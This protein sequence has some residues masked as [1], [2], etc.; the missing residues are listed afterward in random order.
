MINKVNSF[1]KRV[2]F[3]LLQVLG[4]TSLFASFGCLPAMYGIPVAMY[5]VPG[6]FFTL[7]GKVKNSSNQ[8]I[9]GIRVRVK[10]SGQD[11]E[12]EEEYFDVVQTDENGS[13]HLY[14]NCMDSS[15]LDFVISAEDID[16]DTNGAYDNKTMNVE[17]TNTEYTETSGF[18]N[19]IYEM[20]DKNISLDDKN[21]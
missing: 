19:K 3:K 11:S 16:G 13:Y 10:S 7:D 4:I 2:F 8:P 17:F 15:Q 21:S 14:W 9:Q 5:G 18:G 12:D 20:N 1:I 6:N